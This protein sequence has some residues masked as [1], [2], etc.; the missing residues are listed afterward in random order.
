MIRVRRCCFAPSPTPPTRLLGQAAV[1]GRHPLRP[2]DGAVA[3]RYGTV[4]VEGL[5]PAKLP[6]LYQL[7]VY[8]RHCQR[9]VPPQLHQRQVAHRPAT[10]CRRRRALNPLHLGRSFRKMRTQLGRYRTSSTKIR[11]RL[12]SCAKWCFALTGLWLR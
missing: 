11:S 9:Q 10:L 6:P 2:E 12:N 7:Q 3:A 8:A 5:C 1:A 4:P